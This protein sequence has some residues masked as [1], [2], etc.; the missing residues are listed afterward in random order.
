MHNLEELL[1]GGYRQNK[2][3]KLCCD[4]NTFP[5]ALLECKALELLDI[6]GNKLSSLPEHFTG[7]Y[8]LQILFA[9]DNCFKSYPTVLSRMPNLR[10]VAF[11]NNS[12][13]DIEEGS[14]NPNLRWLILTNNK[15]TQLPKVSS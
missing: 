10:I 12:M 7:L 15:L 13:K 6:S 5:L 2:A 9:S 8:N 1:N 11:R 14:L 3:I 4:L